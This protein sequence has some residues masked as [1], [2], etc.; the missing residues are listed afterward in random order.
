MEKAFADRL[1]EGPK[2]PPVAVL[3]GIRAVSH[4]NGEAVFETR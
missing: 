3:V 2:T 1:K 4:G